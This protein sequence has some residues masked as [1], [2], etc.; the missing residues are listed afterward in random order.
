MAGSNFIPTANASG[1]AGSV[2]LAQKAQGDNVDW[3]T[4][5]RP[6]CRV[7]GD[8]PKSRTLRISVFNDRRGMGFFSGDPDQ[9]DTPA[10]TLDD[11]GV[12]RIRIG[13]GSERVLYADLQSGDYQLP[14]A[15]TIYV[16][17]ARYSPSGDVESRTVT[18]Q[19]EIV[20]GDAYDFHPLTYTGWCQLAAGANAEI[21]IPSGAY[22]CDV[23]SEADGTWDVEGEDGPILEITNGPA[24]A[25]RNY[26]D[27]S[28]IAP[29]PFPIVCASPSGGDP[30]LE[31]TN[32]AATG[33]HV[34]KVVFYVR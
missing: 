22:A 29:S 19:G 17:V 15:T 1:R 5:W 20:D 10:R 13:E 16:D 4:S 12:M 8:A 30:K 32:Q 18:V 23:Q 34:C 21:G 11:A 9:M 25:Y 27:G 31:I 2:E 26:I 28:M 24:Y 14:G 7:I 6:L 3:P 33:T